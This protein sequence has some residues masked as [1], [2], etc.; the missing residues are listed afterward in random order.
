[1]GSR[2]ERL[3]A[4]HSYRLVMLLILS[5]FV[6]AAV[7]PDSDW[8]ASLLLLIE[9]A[10]LV[11]AGWTA[12]MARSDSRLSVALLALA[13]ASALALLVFGGDALT[14]TVGL[15]S[16]VL[17]VATIAAIAVGVIDQSE[18]NAES[19][20]GAICIY[21]LFGMVFMFVYGAIAVLGSAPFF[22]QGTDGTRAI[23]LYFSYVTQATLGYG[24]YTPAAQVGR[25]VAIVEALVGQ[26]YL[27]TVVAVL[28]SRMRPRRSVD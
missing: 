12:G 20:T 3:H 27:V 6:F 21:L 2:V 8:S 5:S 26:L 9:S 14:A 23:R 25:T 10:T 28:V 24:D 1:M 15:L 22:A 13:A 16:G 19:V 17:A 18:V 11:A 7:A 4:S